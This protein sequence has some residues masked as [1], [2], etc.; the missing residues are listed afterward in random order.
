MIEVHT[1]GLCEPQNPG[2]HGTYGVVVYT[3]KT[4]VYLSGDVG[5]GPEMS[6]QVAEYHA[7]FKALEYLAERELT[8]EEIV[9][10]TDSQLVAYQ[11]N[12]IWA[13]RRG[14]YLGTYLKV[15]KVAECFTHLRF[16]WIPREENEKADGL[17]RR[18]YEDY[19]AEKGIKPK[20]R[21]R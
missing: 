11:M 4:V 2:G 14:M 6:N 7:V 12:G 15:K 10:Y 13:A 16:Q 3:G 21:R 1:D 8:K 18:A 19:C 17:S 5:S 20:Y 9:V